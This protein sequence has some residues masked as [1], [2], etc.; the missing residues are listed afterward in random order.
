MKEDIL[1][2][3]TEMFLSLGFKSVTMDDIAAEMGISKKTIYQHFAN[4]DELVEAV[5][6]DLF[7]TISNGIDAI[8][9]Q[10]LN[11]IEEIFEIKNFM[12]RQ[13]KNENA[14]PFHQLRK[15][16]PKV[17]EALKS[18]QYCKM[19]DSVHENLRRGIGMGLYRPEIDVNFIT[20]IYYVG[21]SAIK[22]DDV[23]P[24]EQ[25]SMADLTEKYLEYH[26]RA[27]VSA[28]GLAVLNQ[29]LNKPNSTS[30]E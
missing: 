10:E 24:R 19:E 4:K 22:D 20:R 23:F 7:D 26:L 6:M 1:K 14:S 3:A 15:Y 16:F 30:Y 11:P 29:I 12:T 21:G 5:A 17:S 18:N 13:L 28:K 8:R 9:R 25:F 2:R 27:I